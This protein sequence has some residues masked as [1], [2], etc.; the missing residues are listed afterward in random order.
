VE[1]CLSHLTMLKHSNADDLQNVT[2]SSTQ[3]TML[4]LVKVSWTSDQ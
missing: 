4:S 3:H 1:K 2:S